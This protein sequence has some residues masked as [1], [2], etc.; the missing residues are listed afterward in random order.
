MAVTI[1]GVQLVAQTQTGAMLQ[2][3]GVVNV[4]G[5]PA[6][7]SI[8]VFPGDKIETMADG[9]ARLTSPGSLVSL[10]GNSSVTYGNGSVE[11]GCG[12]TTMSTQGHT[13]SAQVGN[14]VISPASDVAKFELARSDKGLQIGAREGSLLID[15]GKEKATLESGKAMSFDVPGECPIPEPEVAKQGAKPAAFS[16]RSKKVLLISAL[17]A[18]AVTAGVVTATSSTKKCISPKNPNKCD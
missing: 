14:L 3:S 5:K 4:N 13:L 17:A 9:S 15:D 8:A 10:P 7:G 2:S 18:G 11:M 12:S 16:L 1:A 6:P